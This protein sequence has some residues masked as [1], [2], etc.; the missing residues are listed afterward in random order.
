MDA[1][2]AVRRRRSPIIATVRSKDWRR[3]ST[4]SKRKLSRRERHRRPAREPRGGHR[5][6]QPGVHERGAR[7]CATRATRSSC[8]APYYFNHEMAIVMAGAAPV[9]VPTTRRVSAGR[10]RDCRRHH[11]AHPRG[12]DR[13]AE[14]PDRR[15]VSRGRAARGQRAAAATRRLPHSRRGV[16]VLH[17]RRRA[18][19][20]R[21]AR[22]TGPAAHTISLYSLSK[23]YGMA[24]WRLGYMVIPER[25]VGCG[26]QDAGHA[27]DLRAGR[28]A[29]RRAR[30]ACAWARLRGARLAGLDAHAPPACTARSRR[31]ACR[32]RRRCRPARSTSS[33]AS[34][35]SLSADG[36]HRAAHPR[37]SRGRDSRVGLRRPDAL[38]DP[39]VVRRARCR[40]GGRRTSTDWSAAFARLGGVV[41]VIT[42]N[43]NGI[44]ARQARARRSCSPPSSPTSCASRRSRRRPTRCRTCSRRPSGYWCYWHGAGGYSGVA[45]AR[46]PQFFH[47]TSDLESS[48]F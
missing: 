11:A 39:R 13:L 41:K 29:A 24:S 43:V 19:T 9:P 44:R 1:V 31:P 3:S 2:R 4:R 47:G 26:Q 40:H 34:D 35:S 30:R 12:G 8:P 20:S 37:A 28:V 21:R 27:A 48:V 23:A 38:L 22:S 6:R 25:A 33:S 18:A 7:H 32:A 10:R 36:A 46:P 45:A 17:V 16:R 42:W 5:R 14:Q 15:G